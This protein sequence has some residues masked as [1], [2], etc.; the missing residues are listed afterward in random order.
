MEM[1]FFSACSFFPV[2]C[3]ENL[4]LL[5]AFSH[6]LTLARPTTFALSKQTKAMAFLGAPDYNQVLKLSNAAVQRVN[7]NTEKANTMEVGSAR[8]MKGNSAEIGILKPQY[9]DF[10]FM[11][12]HLLMA[13]IV[14]FSF[15]LIIA[16]DKMWDTFLIF[17]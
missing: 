3:A 15:C 17:H 12:V 9:T 14:V 16:D 5:N 1:V 8:R 2:V 10:L 11:E 4:C 13:F 6:W 7:L